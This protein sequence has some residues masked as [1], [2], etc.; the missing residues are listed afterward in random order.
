MTTPRV[1][2]A[3]QLAAQLRDAGLAATH[4]PA[5]VLGLVPCV[6]FP[7]PELAFDV[8]DGATVTWRPLLIAGSA[9][10]LDAWTQLDALLVELADRL[11]VETAR[12]TRWAPGPGADGH[13]A[14]VLTFT[15][16]L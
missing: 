16:S 9:V 14:Y 4:D 6:L 3:A 10:E 2:R 13:P 1:T 8:G 15:E 5:E 7:P 12:T 11:P